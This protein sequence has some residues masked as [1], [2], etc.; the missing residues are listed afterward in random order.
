[1]K[2]KGFRMLRQM[3]NL[4][5][6]LSISLLFW[7]SSASA[8]DND[9]SKMR[10]KPIQAQFIAALGDGTAQS[11][12]IHNDWA[13]WEVD[14][15][16]RGVWLRNYP[17]LVAAQNKADAGWEFDPENFWIDENGLLMEK[18]VFNLEP[19]YYLVTG[20][21]EVITVLTVHE[22]AADGSQRW[23]LYNGATLDDVTHLPCRSARYTPIEGAGAEGGMCTPANAPLSEFKVPPG[24]PMPQIEHCVKQDFRVLIVIGLPATTLVSN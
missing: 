16:P 5:S 21:R 12:T 23:E 3:A 17:D 22:K 9:V 10:F 14:P 20:E 7:S 19:G 6:L 18:P 2:N 13:I 1:M 8:L 15:G 24:S 11:G 4:V